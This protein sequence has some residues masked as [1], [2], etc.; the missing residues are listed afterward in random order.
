MNTT[1]SKNEDI[2]VDLSNNV[3]NIS[4]IMAHTTKKLIN[5]TSREFY[6]FVSKFDTLKQLPIILPVEEACL[7]T[8]KSPCGNGTATFSRY[9]LR[10]YQR[11]FK[12]SIADKDITSI[13]EFLKH[14]PV[15]VQFK[16]D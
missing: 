7:T 15:D 10:V 9:K 4:I 13:V 11:L 5:R 1:I 14:S 3:R 16:A 6:D 8:R 2:P 12:L